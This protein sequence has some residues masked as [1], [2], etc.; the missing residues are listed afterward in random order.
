M[1]GNIY[2]LNCFFSSVPPLLKHYLCSVP[3]FYGH[4]LYLR[5]RTPVQVVAGVPNQEKCEE[6]LVFWSQCVLT[7]PSCLLPRVKFPLHHAASEVPEY[8]SLY[9]PLVV[10]S[11]QIRQDPTSSFQK[12]HWATIRNSSDSLPPSAQQV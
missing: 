10:S 6:K 12:H 8:C 2:S 1:R 3:L 5:Y 9:V 4:T 11:K 7:L